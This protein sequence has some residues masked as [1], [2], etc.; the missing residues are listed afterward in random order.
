MGRMYLYLMIFLDLNGRWLELGKCPDLTT[1]FY[2]QNV[3]ISDDIF[4]S[5]WYDA[6]C[7]YRQNVSISDDIFGSGW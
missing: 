2:G 3:S 6:T 7:F 1:C 4:G 5:E